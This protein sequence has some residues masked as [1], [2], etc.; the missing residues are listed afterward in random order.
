ML[1]NRHRKKSRRLTHF[2]HLRSRAMSMY[3]FVFVCVTVA[4]M[5][6]NKGKIFDNPQIYV[7]SEIQKE[8]LAHHNTFEECVTLEADSLFV[9]VVRQRQKI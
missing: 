5:N 3:V 1:L 8:L 4:S 7:S 9:I 2:C 6:K